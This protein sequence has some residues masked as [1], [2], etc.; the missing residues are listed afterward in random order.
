MEQAWRPPPPDLISIPEPQTMLDYSIAL[1]KHECN[2]LKQARHA[3]QAR[4]LFLSMDPIRQ[5]LMRASS[6]Q[7]G[8]DSAHC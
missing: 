4:E 5:T 6:G 7:C 8:M 1:C 2:L 3:K